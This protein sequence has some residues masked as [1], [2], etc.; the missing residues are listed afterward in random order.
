MSSF[1]FSS[2]LLHFN[3]KFVTQKRPTSQNAARG[4]LFSYKNQK[5]EP[6]WGSSSRSM[7]GY[8]T[9]CSEIGKITITLQII[10]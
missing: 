8:H 3:C 9:E 4:V 7:L 2:Y 1:L 6:R 5:E 10:L